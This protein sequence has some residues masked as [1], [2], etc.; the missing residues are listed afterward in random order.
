VGGLSLTY[1]YNIQLAISAVLRW[2]DYKP[3]ENR[4]RERQYGI[5]VPEAPGAFHPGTLYPSLE[6][7][8]NFDPGTF[9]RG[10]VGATPGGTICSGGVCR[11]V[12]PFE[13]LLL[14]FVGRL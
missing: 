7:R 8:W 14:Q 2:S 13:G 3:G 4:A 9:V 11:E 1:T 10:F 6:I 12:P 5:T